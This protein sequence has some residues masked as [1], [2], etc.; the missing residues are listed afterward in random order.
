MEDYTQPEHMDKAM[1]VRHPCY[2]YSNRASQG[3]F[4]SWMDPDNISLP[5]SSS[6]AF[7]GT[8]PSLCV[9]SLRDRLPGASLPVLLAHAPAVCTSCRRWEPILRAGAGCLAAKCTHNLDK[10][11]AALSAP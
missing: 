3:V 7:G 2:L 4:V 10:R 1:R 11:L 8:A 9:D 6:A 5:M